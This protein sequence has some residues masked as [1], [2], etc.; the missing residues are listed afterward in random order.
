MPREVGSSVPEE[1]FPCVLFTYLSRT[2]TLNKYVSISNIYCLLPFGVVW[3]K[4]W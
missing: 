1:Q 2:R 3:T 4:W